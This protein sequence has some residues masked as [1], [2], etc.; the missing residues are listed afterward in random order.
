MAFHSKKEFA[1]MCGMTTGNLSNYIGR[2]KVVLSGELIDDTISENIS[3]SLKHKKNT[4]TEVAVVNGPK[5]QDPDI[6]RAAPNI[7]SKRKK[8]DNEDGGVGWHQLEK[9][10][11]ALDIEK[12]AEEITKLQLWNQKAQGDSIP[13]DLVREVFMR[14]SKNISSSFKSGIENLL[15]E[16]EKSARLDR[17]QTSKL[18]GDMIKTINTAVDSAVTESKKEVG[19]IVKEYSAKKGVGEHE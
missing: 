14:L 9:Q 18:R 5:I 16:F 13:T 3:F 19:N 12:T 1:E 6:V 10:K 7:T 4:S 11:K 17:A 15:I 2:K 8:G